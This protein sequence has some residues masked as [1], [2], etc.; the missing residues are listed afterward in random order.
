MSQDLH[1]LVTASTG[2][3]A[4]PDAP[5]VYAAE[6]AVA[7]WLDLVTPDSPEVT[8]HGKL[9]CPDPDPKFS[10]PEA[11]GCYLEKVLA[12]LT[13][14]EHTFNGR[15]LLP[16]TV[17]SRRGATRAVYEFATAT[18]A[19]PPA[20]IGGRWALR[21]LVALH[22]LAHH[23][24][25]EPGHGAEWRTTFLRLL[26]AVGQSEHAELLHLAYHDE[27]LSSLQHEV[28][29]S[30]LEKIAKLLRQGERATN[31]H[32]RDAFLARAQRLASAA[33]V[34]LAVARAHGE[35]AEAREEP[36][37]TRVSIGTRGQ[38]GLA[39]YVRL[40][41]NIAAA[42]DVECTIQHGSVAVNLHGFPSDLAT[43]QA[44]YES[45]MVQMVAEF[46]AYR[47]SEVVTEEW[48]WSERFQ[49]YEWKKPATLSRRLAFY[50][51]F[52]VR[53]GSR[54]QEARR[55]AIAEATRREARQAGGLR[56]SAVTEVAIRRKEIEVHDFFAA[57]L[58]AQGITTS[59][60]GDRD[61]AG[62]RAPAASKAGTRAADRAELGTER[63]LS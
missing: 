33:S 27:G 17:R 34:A 60:R 21:G 31:P 55:A 3:S 63:A 5:A 16:V 49:D 13:E 61:P 40:L 28:A 9:F 39:R 2:T 25:G 15:E 41:L 62:T 44:L 14:S 51:A 12:H 6:N 4:D 53:V 52:G 32:E 54:L 35:G 23:L 24:Q 22:E 26:E 19:V 59:W 30:T 20:E 46:E 50:E 1:H 48:I 45:L 11:F 10:D 37:V 8:V 18:V 42:N 29:E 47:A 38:R 57:R 36:T 58:R 43:T 56:S 7:Q